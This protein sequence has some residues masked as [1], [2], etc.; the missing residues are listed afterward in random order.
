MTL[1]ESQEITVVPNSDPV[2]KRKRRKETRPR[3]RLEASQVEQIFTLTTEGKS[4]KEIADLF[5]VT[6]GAISHILTGRRRATQ[7]AIESK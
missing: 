2:K 7:K 5:K 6:Q 4:Q 3:V 1:A